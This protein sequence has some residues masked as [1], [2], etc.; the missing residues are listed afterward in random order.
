[1]EQVPHLTAVAVDSDR[2]AGQRAADE[3][4]NPALVLGPELVRAVDAAHPEH[5]RG[6]AEAAGVLAHILVGTAF[7]APVGTGEV[8]LVRFVDASARDRLRG[9]V[10]TA[11]SH[12]A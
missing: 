3:M 11:P 6:Q 8:E 7:G 2:Q 12:E 1:M 4:G 9:L 5:D 10:A